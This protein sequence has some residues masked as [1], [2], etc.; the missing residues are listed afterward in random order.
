[1]LFTGKIKLFMLTYSNIL[2]RLESLIHIKNHKKLPVKIFLRE[3]VLNYRGRVN[4]KRRG[5]DH[6]LAIVKAETA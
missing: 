2:C 1:M 6:F 5:T 3:Y 4:F